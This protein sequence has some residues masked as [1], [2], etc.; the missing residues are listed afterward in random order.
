MQIFNKWPP[1]WPFVQVGNTH[2]WHQTLKNYALSFSSTWKPQKKQYILCLL[3]NVSCMFVQNCTRFC[4]LKFVCQAAMTSSCQKRVELNFHTWFK[5][6][7][8]ALVTFSDWKW[9]EYY[10]EIIVK[11]WSEFSQTCCIITE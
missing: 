2:Q 5:V 7:K 9:S 6:L 4:R 11:I 8:E 10:L 1:L 3:F